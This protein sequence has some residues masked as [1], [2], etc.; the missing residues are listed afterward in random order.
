MAFAILS[1]G[2]SSW[3]EEYC[4]VHSGSGLYGDPFADE[5]HREKIAVDETSL[6]IQHVK[7]CVDLGSPRLKSLV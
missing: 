4:W 6:L 5:M 2:V 7:E 3:R 1:A